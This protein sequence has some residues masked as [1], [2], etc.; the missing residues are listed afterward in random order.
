MTFTQWKAQQGGGARPT[1]QPASNLGSVISKPTT[2]PI[3]FSQWKAQQSTVKTTTDNA[4]QPSFLEKANNTF[5]DVSAGAGKS[6]LDLIRGTGELGGSLVNWVM[7]KGFTPSAKGGLEFSDTGKKI[8]NIN[9]T[10]KNVA[11]TVGD[12]GGTIA[13][14]AVPGAEAENV[15][16]DVTE[17]LPKAGRFLADEAGNLTKWGKA[18]SYG[19]KSLVRGTTAGTVTAAQTGSLKKGAQMGET[20]AALDV[21]VN[22]AGNLLGGIFKNLASFVSGKG[23]VV[24]DSI[25]NDPAATL[26]G[27]KTD[28][29][30]GLRKTVSALQQ[31]ASDTYKAAQDKYASALDDIEKKYLPSNTDFMKQGNKMITPNGTVN[32]TLKGVKDS[33]TKIFSDFG[34]EGD[35]SKGFNFSNAPSVG[36]KNILNTA[37][38]AVKDFTDITPKGIIN[39]TRRLNSIAEKTKL[40]EAIGAMSQIENNLKNYLGEKIPEIGQMNAQYA[41]SMKFLEDMNNYLRTGV[42]S[43]IKEGMGVEK[44]VEQIATEVATLFN[45]NKELARQW[46]SGL[47]N[48]SKILAGQAGR[49]ME[50]GLRMSGLPGGGGMVSRALETMVPPKL[51]GWLVARGSQFANLLGK[52]TPA[53]Q[54]LIRELWGHASSSQ[55]SRSQT[56]QQGQ[57]GVTA[58]QSLGQALEGHQQQ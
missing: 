43:G 14:F 33:I 44:N 4:N 48:G 39:L 21:P 2:K 35:F 38:R 51:T 10:P 15:I 46:I 55:A 5:N 34:V 36:L 18:A 7:G 56:S 19:I 24:I 29:A 3:S 9:T 45:N 31:Y 17:L 1:P 41:K 57:S 40:P 32:L 27:M 53:E 50:E 37:Y 30:T 16:K 11:E 58:P 28:A 47:P 54:A 6:A 23:K 13:Q 22:W 26:Q 12:V 8:E 20:I 25:V 42:K 49:L 52:L